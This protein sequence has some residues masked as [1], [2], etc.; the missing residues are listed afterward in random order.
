MRQKF[1]VL[2]SLDLIAT[3]PSSLRSRVVSLRSS[4]PLLLLLR[5]PTNP[6]RRAL[7]MLYLSES[8]VEEALMALVHGAEWSSLPEQLKELQPEMWKAL[9]SLLLSTYK[10]RAMSTVH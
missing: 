1:S 3:T 5:L 7:Q 6:K 2:K 8:L 4:P 9:G 10:V